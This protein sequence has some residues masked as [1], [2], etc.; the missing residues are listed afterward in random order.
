MFFK[1]ILFPLPKKMLRLT[2]NN[3]FPPHKLIM[4]TKKYQIIKMIIFGIGL[5]N[6]WELVD[7]QL[8][9]FSGAQFSKDIFVKVG[10]SGTA[11]L[12][13]DASDASLSTACSLDLSISAA[14]SSVGLPGEFLLTDSLSL[15]LVG[16]IL[17]FWKTKR[18]NLNLNNSTQ[19][20]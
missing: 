13:R 1:F 6:T 20:R 5:V 10:L 11:L 15:Q 3:S 18:M 16:S 12:L 14:A 17:G 4:N 19:Q 8:L 2:S 7:G 9:F